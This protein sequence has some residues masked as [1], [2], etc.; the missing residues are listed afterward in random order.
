[1]M[2]DI[3]RKIRKIRIYKD[4]GGGFCVLAT[5]TFDLHINILYKLTSQVNEGG[6]DALSCLGFFISKNFQKKIKKF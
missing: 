2:I 4:F 3:I 1:M 5:R 6:I